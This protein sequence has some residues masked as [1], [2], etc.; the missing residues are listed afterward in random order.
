MTEVVELVILVSRGRYVSRGD[1]RLNI[2]F[3]F[4]W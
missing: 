3:L 2:R 4:L 1:I